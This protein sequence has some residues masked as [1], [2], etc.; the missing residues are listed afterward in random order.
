MDFYT[1]KP[2]GSGRCSP[3]R[4]ASTFRYHRSETIQ[5]RD[6]LEGP[7]NTS[8]GHKRFRRAARAALPAMLQKREPPW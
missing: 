3:R 8:I 1:A 6:F 7:A 2:N 4:S 5:F